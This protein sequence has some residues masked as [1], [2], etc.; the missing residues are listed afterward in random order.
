MDFVY[1]VDKALLKKYDGKIL[2]ITFNFEVVERL[3]DSRYHAWG[4]PEQSPA[5]AYIVKET[6]AQGNFK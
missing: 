4:T 1:V 2:Q 6:P 3:I 5:A